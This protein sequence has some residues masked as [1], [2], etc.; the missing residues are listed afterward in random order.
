[1]VGSATA[2]C[3]G[4]EAGLHT[5]LNQAEL[6]GQVIFTGYRD[7]VSELMQMAD[8]VVI[9]SLTE[10]QPRV[11]VQ[12]FAVGKPVV[13]S[14]VGGVPE[15]VFDGD[16]GWLVPP[17]DPARL[18]EAM[19]RVMTDHDTTRA[20]AARA[21]ILAEKQMR[22]DTRMEQTLETY[23]TAMAHARRRRLP[24]FKGVQA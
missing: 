22:F 1:M 19:E 4:Y 12:A 16:T 23:R 14:D 7:D 11:A 24:R 17:A 6:T 13:A 9:P 18:A 20:V 3:A 10:A 15:I 5:Q 2:E 21:R 8:A